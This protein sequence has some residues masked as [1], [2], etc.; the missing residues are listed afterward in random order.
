MQT[1]HLSGLWE[2]RHRWQFTYP[3]FN[4]CLLSTYCAPEDVLD[5]G[6]IAVNRADEVSATMKLTL[7]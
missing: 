3:Y 4:A 7:Y 2:L 1:C 5:A 6:N